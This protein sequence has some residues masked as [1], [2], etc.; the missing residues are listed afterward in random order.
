MEF[1]LATVKFR[2]LLLDE[3]N[4]CADHFGDFLA[5][6]EEFISNNAPSEINIDSKMKYNIM[7][8]AKRDAYMELTVVRFKWQRTSS[9]LELVSDRLLTA[10]LRPP[11]VTRKMQDGSHQVGFLLCKRF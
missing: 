6:A 11:P 1:L 7:K 5:I 9:S 8:Y 2:T 3:S 10:P 4:K